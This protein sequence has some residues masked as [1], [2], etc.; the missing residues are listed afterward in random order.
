MGLI[1]IAARQRQVGPIHFAACSDAV[2][3]ILETLDAAEQFRRQSNLV[4]EN[5]DKAA[6]TEAD[7]AA[8]FG[9]GWGAARVSKFMQGKID[10][11]M[12]EQRLRCVI[13]QAFFHDL[14]LSFGRGR[15]E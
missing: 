9:D 11:G 5:V 3:N 4:M 14:K 1:E 13:E 7:L 6:G 12:P 15:L 8:D 10:S 2:Q